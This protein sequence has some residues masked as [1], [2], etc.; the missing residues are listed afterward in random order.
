MEKKGNALILKGEDGS[1]KMRN[2]GHVK[3][4]GTIPEHLQFHQSDSSVNDLGESPQISDGDGAVS[5][6][7]PDT[8]K[9]S[10]P[11]NLQTILKLNQVRVHNVSDI[12][13][14]I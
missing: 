12:D 4:F 2:S 3:K 9:P 5:Q 6:P 14:V 10:E 8:Q 7:V 13:Q 11:P 1:I